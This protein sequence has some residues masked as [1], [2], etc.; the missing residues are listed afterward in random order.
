MSEPLLPD[1]Y[2]QCSD[3][4]NLFKSKEEADDHKINNQCYTENQN[5]SLHVSCSVCNQVFNKSEQW[6]QHLQPDVKEKSKKYQ[7]KM[8][9]KL[10]NSKYSYQRHEKNNKC[11]QDT[12][13]KLF[14]CQNCA[15]QFSKK[16]SLKKHTKFNV[17]T[18]KKNQKCFVDNCKTYF[19]KCSDLAEH[20][21]IAHGNNVTFE[22]SGTAWEVMN[23]TFASDREFHQWLVTVSDDY[24]CNYFTAVVKH[25][26]G[27]SYTVYKCQYDKR[28]YQN[29]SSSTHSTKSNPNFFCP[30]RICCKKTLYGPVEVTY[31]KTHNH[32]ALKLK[33]S[34][35][36]YSRKTRPPTET[37]QHYIENVNFTD[38]VINMDTSSY[39]INHNSDH[40]NIVLE[41]QNHLKEV[42]LAHYQ[43]NEFI[44]TENML[45]EN[46]SN[47]VVGSVE[48][49]ENIQESAVDPTGSQVKQECE[50]TQ[51]PL[52]TTGTYIIPLNS[53]MEYKHNDNIHSGKMNRRLKCDISE[54]FSKILE[55]VES[56]DNS[57][58]LTFVKHDLENVLDE[59]VK[60]KDENEFEEDQ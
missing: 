15:L 55:Y 12:E 49:D 53:V 20:V 14:Q 16:C 46:N 60:F 36:D 41:E 38:E 10:F 18:N 3:C 44:Q 17:C 21:K 29:K 33:R 37:V 40:N 30:S 43:Q 54:L 7:C 39:H 13:M 25:V 11:C 4:L 19:R 32:K 50:T 31:Y 5:E 58:L 6:C 56:S 22:G 23:L 47:L 48:I 27:V 1:F 34:R 24:N 9:K 26:N 8:C 52:N 51:D 57:Q 35:I 28:V 42:T 2:L 45:E 59:C